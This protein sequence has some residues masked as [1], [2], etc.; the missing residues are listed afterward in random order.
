MNRKILVSYDGSNRSKKAIKE[1]K[2]QA[3]I[4]EKAEVHVISVVTPGIKSNDTAIAGNISMSDAEFL[5][6]ELHQI[7]REMEA[8]GIVTI[9]EI[10]TDFS[11]RN[12][13]RAIC[14]Y[15]LA[16][17]I[18]LIIVG[19]R[20]LSNIKSLLLG[21]VSNTIVQNAKCPVLIVK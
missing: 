17:E 20:G 4:T 3:S 12:P 19:N 16:N 14:E 15:A 8:L 7:K 21:G 5:L 11:Q 2:N 13:G 6:P 18:D 1:A 10:R 9:T